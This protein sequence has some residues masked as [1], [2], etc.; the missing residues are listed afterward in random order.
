MQSKA[1]VQHR[2]A[3]KVY[4]MTQGTTVQQAAKEHLLKLQ[5]RTPYRK[6]V[7]EI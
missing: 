2:A 3:T 1:Q 4:S 7:S 5:G 6:Q